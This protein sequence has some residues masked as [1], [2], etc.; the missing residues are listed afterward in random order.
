MTGEIPASLGLLHNLF[1]LDLS[2]NKLSGKPRNELLLLL[3]LLLLLFAMMST[4]L[5]IIC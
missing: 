4:C 2:H 3:L 5:V 1:W